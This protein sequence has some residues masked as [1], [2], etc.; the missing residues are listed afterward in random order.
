M[1]RLPYATPAQFADLVRQCG[2]PEHTPQTNAFFMLAHTPA[3]GARL[4]QMVFALLTQTD[5][6]PRVRELVI[7]R[8]A[9]RC[10]GTYAW[11]QHV[12]I[13]RAV[14]VSDAHIAALEQGEAPVDLFD[15]QERTAFDFAD[16]VLDASRCADDTFSAVHQIFSPRQ[17]VELL[18]LIGYFRMICG[19]MTT[20]DVEAEPPF[21]VKVLNLTRDTDRTNNKSDST[22]KESSSLQRAVRVAPVDKLGGGIP[23]VEFHSVLRLSS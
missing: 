19:L 13:A 17:V 9:E 21:G 1:T 4:L 11:G 12:V 8:V 6:D 23:L 3:V 18:L 5:L 7:L 16:G 14:G 15:D 22:E 2:L 10:H 20:L